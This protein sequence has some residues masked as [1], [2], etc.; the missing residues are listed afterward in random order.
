MLKMRTSSFHAMIEILL[1]RFPSILEHFWDNLATCSC[2][3]KYSSKLEGVEEILPPQKEISRRQMLQVLE[4][5]RNKIDV[6]ESFFASL[7]L[8]PKSRGLV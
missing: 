7:R 6:S 1:K 2:C 8:L 3:R 5:Y 4:N